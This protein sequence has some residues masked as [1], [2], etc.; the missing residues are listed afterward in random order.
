MPLVKNQ[1]GYVKNIKPPASGPSEECIR[2][3]SKC[4]E[5]P[6]SS[7]PGLPI[8]EVDPYKGETGLD[9]NVPVETSNKTAAKST[10]SSPKKGS[11]SI[12]SHTLKKKSTPWKYK[13]KICGEVLDSVH[14]LTTHHQINPHIL[15]CSTCRKAF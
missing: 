2:A 10:E 4:P 14:E 3:Q 5:Q 6:S 9:S 15:Y 11:I 13:C 8:P 12:T 7:L 1:T